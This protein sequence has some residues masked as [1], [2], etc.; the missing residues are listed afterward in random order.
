MH[1]LNEH[2]VVRRYR[3]KK[4]VVLSV[5]LSLLVASAVVAYILCS[6]QLKN[7]TQDI[8][9]NQREVQQSWVDKSL[10]AIR[11]W[12]IAVVEQARLVSGAE[13]FRL[14]AV[15]VRNMGP[16]APQRLSAPDA[17]ETGDESVRN[18]A[19]QMRYMQ[20]LLRD[21]ALSRH[22][23][24]ARVVTPQGR[25]L[26]AHEDELPLGEA[27]TALVRRAVAEKTMAYG[28]VRVLGDALVMDV[29]DPMYEVLGRGENAPVAALLATIPMDKALVSFLTFRQDQYREFLPRIVQKGEA[30]P[31]AV[32]LHEG[33][34]VIEPV[35]MPLADD[36]LAFKRRTRFVG[37]GEAYSLGS[38]LSGLGWLVAL[39]A[40][41][42]LVDGVVESQ[43]RQIY[44]LG[45]LGSLG[46]ALLLAFMWATLVSRS[47]RATAQHFQQLYALIRQQKLMLD[48]VNASLQAGLMLM[49]SEGR[50]QMCNPA[51]SQMAGKSETALQGGQ[52]GRALPQEAADRLLEGMAKVSASGKEGS[53]EVSLAQGQASRLY[54]VTLF[55]FEESTPQGEKSLGGCVCIFQDITEF[56]RRAD[57]ARLRQA[58]SIAGLVRAIESVDVNLIGHSLKMEHV[59]DILSGSMNLNDRD[60]ET[61][62]LAARLSQVGKIFVPR[63]LLTKKGKLTQEEQA[64]VMRAPEYAYG[65]LRDMQFNLP[66]PEAVFQMGERMD[67][68]GL[69]R[70]LAGADIDRNARILAVINAFCAMVS[71]RSY[72]AGMSPEE[73]V[74][75]LAKD[76]GFDSEVVAALAAIPVEDLQ[77]VIATAEACGK[78]NADD[79]AEPE[80]A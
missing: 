75:L 30:G 80:C 38:Y 1:E 8:L 56:R 70:H 71:P 42:D 24:S 58:N 74:T 54:R 22:W 28:P 40:P 34:A 3:L 5:S 78:K 44:G 69:P 47:H 73:A 15:D 7:V 50:L 12:N 16:D 64:E 14:F 72:R 18:L 49:D 62:R 67:G 27:Q 61:L 9:G 31:E 52:I 25:P 66:V 43:A 32:L 21:F 20:D 13:M 33:R 57:E 48:S 29:A 26:I 60:R 23:V 51:F 45:L 46:T 2:A 19:E 77:R 68:S 55:P 4:A 53:I 35:Q 39:E 41:A 6:L 10:E 36:N 59:A 76:A 17:A 11:A 63:D 79:A 65:I 37:S